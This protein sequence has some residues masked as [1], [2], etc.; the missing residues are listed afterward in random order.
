MVS[1]PQRTSA[2]GLDGN[3]CK[4]L[5][6]EEENAHQENLDVSMKDGTFD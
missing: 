1:A 2:G 3:T 5:K 6:D 4:E